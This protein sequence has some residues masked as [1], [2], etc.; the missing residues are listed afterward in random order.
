MHHPGDAWTVVSAVAL[1][2]WGTGGTQYL[3]RRLLA[4][5][6]VSAHRAKHQAE[7]ARSTPGRMEKKLLLSKATAHVTA[8]DRRLQHVERWHKRVY[9]PVLCALTASTLALSVWGV[10]T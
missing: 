2:A 9:M 7:L 8:N 3:K 1:A 5:V 6:S 10:V 4:P